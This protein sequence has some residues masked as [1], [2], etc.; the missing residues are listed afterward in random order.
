MTA[1]GIVFERRAIQGENEP[2]FTLELP[3]PVEEL[4]GEALAAEPPVE[5]GEFEASEL[6]ELTALDPTLRLDVRY[7]ST[8]NFLQARVYDSARAFLQRPAA[9]ALVRAHR[10]LAERGYGILVHDAYRPWYVTKMFWEATP[11]AQHIFVADPSEGSRHNRGCAVDL[12][13]F[14]LATGEPVE[15]TGL[16]DEMSARSYPNYVGGT[17][18]Q[19]WHRELLRDALEAEGFRV[20]EF[21]W[22]H[23]DF[24]GWERWRIQNATFEELAGARGPVR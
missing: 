2:T 23:F 7:A 22:W 4:R 6:V 18:L 10:R 16:Y 12:T 1:A 21:E 24:Q 14:E 17:S 9:E 13:L 15:M 3:R 20:Y 11:A 8:D 5:R 19:R